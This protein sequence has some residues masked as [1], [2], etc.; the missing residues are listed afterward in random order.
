MTRHSDRLVSIVIDNYNY[1]RFLGASIESGLEQTWHRTEV[2]VVDDG[3]TDE[4][5]EVISGYGRSVI[6]ILKSNG[7][8]ASAFNEGFMR[9]RGD[10]IIFL[11]ADDQLLP[12]AAQ[13]VAETFADGPISRA[14]WPMFVIDEGGHRT[15]AM[16]NEA[17]PEG[18]LRSMVLSGGP[19]MYRWSPTSG[20]AWSRALLEAI[21]PIPAS[22]FTNYADNFLSALSPIYG[23]HRSLDPISCWRSHTRN[24]TKQA[25]SVAPFRERLGI[26]VAR[27]DE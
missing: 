12:T 10:P 2:I 3:S 17:L 22:A 20:N 15:G 6:P 5:A 19:Y 8:Q 1:G 7:G 18:D 26:W 21:L 24:E 25:V 9:T 14:Y 27:F 4:S 11:D 23:I 13:T 16:S